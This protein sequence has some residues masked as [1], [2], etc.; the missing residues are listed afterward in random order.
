[1]GV[2][3][4]ALTLSR[5][6]KLLYTTSEEA[7][8]RWGWPLACRREDAPQ[9]APLSHS[10]GAI[11]VVD[12]EKATTTPE[13][14]IV[15]A[16]DAGC[17]PVRL[18][19][20]PS[21]DR[22]YVSER[23]SDRLL[24]FDTGRLL[25]DSGRARIAAVPVGTAPVGIAVVDSGRRLIVTSSN[26]FARP[27]DPQFLTVVA[28]DK[29]DSGALAVVGSVAAGAFPRELHVTADGQ[30]LFLTNYGS[31]TVEMFDL[32][33]LPIRLGVLKP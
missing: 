12:V 32:R 33:R 17:S 2:S 28:A 9:D 31:R 5:D 27:T 6:E 20:S 19:L 1:M 24:V 26:R 4:I 14:S 25:S 23:G 29:V 18:A 10:D 30:T 8:R 3:P 13:M 15:G 16:V 7:P 22:A 11:I 21:G